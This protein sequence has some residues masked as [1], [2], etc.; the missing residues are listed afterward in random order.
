M[1]Y[2][3]YEAAEKDF[4][5]DSRLSTYSETKEK[6]TYKISQQERELSNQQN[7]TK[8]IAFGNIKNSG[9]EA[10]K[11]ASKQ[12][13]KTAT[14]TAASKAPSVV[15]Q[16]VDKAKGGLKK[17]MEY[18][19]PA[20]RS[21]GDEE[22]SFSFMS[23]IASIC[24]ACIGLC[25]IFLLP[26]LCVIITSIT[27]ALVGGN[28]TEVVQVPHV[29]YPSERNQECATCD[30]SGL[31]LCEVCLGETL[32]V[33]TTCSGTRRVLTVSFNNKSGKVPA[34]AAY[35]AQSSY[36]SYAGY[37][38]CTECGG[39]GSCYVFYSTTN[40]NGTPVGQLNTGYKL[41]SGKVSCTNCGGDGR[42]NTECLSCNG[43]G[44]YYHCTN[45]EC[46]YHTW[47]NWESLG[48]DING[49]CYERDV[50]E[51]EYD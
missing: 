9:E 51:S 46:P 37:K 36:Y 10:S 5:K 49:I 7:N 19:K 20:E 42:L 41:G 15:V 34:D 30:G 1:K 23:A 22:N 43:V 24:C 6:N 29:W 17:V 14:S 21:S 28:T 12:A 47:N 18:A 50:E 27:M 13:A 40:C 11:D 45:E 44:V 33:C 35:G 38:G 25:V 26:F 39:T 2:G 8:G 32:A 48:V 16:V 31:N 4:D 3:Y